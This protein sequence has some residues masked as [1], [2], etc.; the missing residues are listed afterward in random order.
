MTSIR[1]TDQCW[2]LSTHPISSQSLGQILSQSVSGPEPE[3]N[4]EP[5]SEAEM[6]LIMSLG[7][8]LSRSL[9]RRRSLSLSQ[10]QTVEASPSA[11]LARFYAATTSA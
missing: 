6:S 9:S 2:E 7:Q 8:S 11:S 1:A 3:P 5:G 10:G 4:S